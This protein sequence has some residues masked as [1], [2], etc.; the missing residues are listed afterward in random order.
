MWEF[1]WLERRWPGAGYE[2]IEAA[3]DQLVD[4]GYDAVRID[5][6]PH[7]VAVDPETEFELLPI[8]SVHRWGA[9]MRC[10]VRIQPHLTDFIAA[11]ASRGIVVGLS[12]WYRRDTSEAWRLLSTPRAEAA[13]WLKVLDIIDDAGLLDAIFYV[14]LCNEWPMRMWAPHFYG[15]D[16]GVA[17]IADE[18]QTRWDDP[19]SL[20]WMQESIEIIRGKYPSLPLTYSIHP[21]DGRFERATFLD[22]FEPHIWMSGGDFYRRVGYTF[23]HRFDNDEY[24]SVRANA[25]R[26]YRSDEAHWR[27][28]LQSRIAEAAQAGRELKKPL[29]TTECWG[30]TDYKDGPGLSWDWVKELCALGVEEA[31]RTGAWAA[32]AT[33]NFCG[34]QFPGM[35]RDIGWHRRLTET[36]R[37]GVVPGSWSWQR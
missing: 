18:T 35:W 27:S 19:P 13:A 26:V 34:P 37:S 1:S 32:I 28:V 12:S 33:S 6:F 17:A 31:S 2:D 5:A 14:D 11:C 9:P 24:E 15:V 8:W 16:E 10:R 22:F 21:W 20:V 29:I 25:E 4:R 23:T 3:L 7:L 36:I 30:I